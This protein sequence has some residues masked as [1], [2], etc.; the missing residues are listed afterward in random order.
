VGA[1]E[2][3]LCEVALIILD[4]VAAEVDEGEKETGSTGWVHEGESLSPHFGHMP[5]PAALPDK[6][7]SVV[8]GRAVPVLGSDEDPDSCPFTGQDIGEA[9]EEGAVHSRG[10][11]IVDDFSVA[12]EDF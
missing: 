4:A 12:H 5:D 2:V 7:Q 11:K 3:G 9:S 1:C 10:N 8:E 6:D